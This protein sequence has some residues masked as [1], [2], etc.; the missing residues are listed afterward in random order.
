MSFDQLAESRSSNEKKKSEPDDVPQTGIYRLNRLKF[1]LLLLIC[2]GVLFFL[3]YL[4]VKSIASDC[5]GMECMAISMALVGLIYL[6]TG[7]I[8]IINLILIVIYER[9]N[10]DKRKY[11]FLTYFYVLIIFASI[12]YGVFGDLFFMNKYIVNPIRGLLLE[13][14]IN[15]YIKNKDINGCFGYIDR[16]S[17]DI[18][19]GPD[20]FQMKDR[21]ATDIALLYKD[22]SMCDY[23]S[24]E[25]SDYLGSCYRQVLGAMSKRPDTSNYRE[26]FNDAQLFCQGLQNDRPPCDF[27][28]FNP[29]YY[30]TNREEILSSCQLIKTPEEQAKCIKLYSKINKEEVLS[31]CDKIRASARDECIEK[32][33]RLI[34]L[35]R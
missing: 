17:F 13:N 21:C 8:V 26:Y 33:S 7:V 4:F 2:T 31:F 28:V 30:I 14:K 22:L 1:Y 3:G 20:K 25:E 27:I 5:N 34:D 12:S 24:S 9:K 32:I 16:L 23:C 15:S 18:Y 11:K 19:N 10:K 35:Q 6:I 29:T